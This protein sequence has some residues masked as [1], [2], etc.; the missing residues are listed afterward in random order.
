MSDFDQL[1]DML[2]DL[3]LNHKIDMSNAEYIYRPYL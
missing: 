1:V 2:T 3:E